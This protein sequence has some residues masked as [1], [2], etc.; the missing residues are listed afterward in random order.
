MF[1][2]TA[3]LLAAL[4][5]N[6]AVFAQAVPVDNTVRLD[7]TVKS[8]AAP[9]ALQQ[10]DF[11]I[12]D[13]KTPVAISAFRGVSEKQ[14]PIQV[15]LVVDELNAPY[16]AIASTL[17]QLGTFL[18][19]NGG[20]LQYPTSIGILT[21]SGLHAQEVFSKDGN[22]LAKSL[23]DSGMTSHSISRG[24]EINALME[25]F[26]ISLTGL[27][28]STGRV[29]DVPGRKIMVWISPGWPLIA[30]IQL[31]PKNHQAFYDAILRT[32]A[33][34]QRARVT[35]YCVDPYGASMSVADTF[36]YEGHLKAVTKPGQAE[37]PNLSLPVLV[38]HSGGELLTGS[39]DVGG[40]IQKIFD[41][42][43]IHYEL[44]YSR[45]PAEHPDE[46]H[47]IEVKIA[48]PGLTAR[49]IDGYYAPHP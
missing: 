14:A 29:A 4:L 19:A 8:N 10:G 40:A 26:Q 32:N 6:A 36:A 33:E 47:H 31:E 30:N 43:E 16:S 42:L 21:A 3:T 41:N 20:K 25:R 39:N 12:L 34:L 24:D 22:V 15:L 5:C 46:Y 35:V 49:T 7:V 48:K 2:C 13:N 18:R 44:S 27:R 45:P 1:T 37:I 23:D 17:H 11:T 38:L 28:A 9:L